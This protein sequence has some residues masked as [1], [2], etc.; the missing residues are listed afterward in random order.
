MKTF[1]EQESIC[2]NAFR[3]NAPFWHLY[4]SGKGMPLLFRD[5]DE[6]RFVMNVIARCS[7]DFPDVW[8][9]SFTLMGNHIHALVSGEHQRC[10][11]MFKI[12]RQRI[13]RGIG[14]LPASFVPYLK[15]VADL[16]TLRNTLVYI[17]R[18]GYVVDKTHT[19]FSYPWGTG[20]FYFNRYSFSSCL[21][22][23]KDS[24]LRLMFKARN[25]GLPEDFLVTDGYVAPPSYCRIGKGMS[26]FRD[27]HQYFSMVSKGVESYMEIAVDL[28]DG[29]FLT[30]NELF[31]QV[32]K[33]V[34]ERYGVGAPKELSNAQRIEMAKVIKREYRSSNDQI[35][36][37]LNLT[38]F[39]VNSIFPLSAARDI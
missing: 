37:V 11:L 26:L 10:L 28:D 3:E 15:P 7:Y 22:D 32:W 39:E 9:V 25:P 31:L 23:L 17:H 35:C 34:R 24:E 1:K 19:P 12:L 27:A 13:A 4:T 29:E 30:D 6:F 36:R 16:R 2:E 38:Q 14:G 5:D 33:F 21:S 8:I 18:N 20:P